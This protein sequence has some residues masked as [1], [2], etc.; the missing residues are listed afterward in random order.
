[1]TLLIAI[2][3]F[4]SSVFS[5]NQTRASS[6]GDDAAEAFVESLE[7]VYSELGYAANFNLQHRPTL[8]K[9]VIAAYP[10]AALDTQVY[11]TSGRV[12]WTQI[13]ANWNKM[14]TENKMT[15]GYIVLAVAHGEPAA[16]QALGGFV[17]GK[18]QSGGQ[19][20]KKIS[21]NYSSGG[22]GGYGSYASDGECSYISSGS[23]TMSTC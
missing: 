16:E 14:S 20:N 3:S 2:F 17:P 13:R 22:A 19:S 12:I 18:N 21:T 7:F 23:V 15:F 6:L 11:L 4:A 8:V 5:Q 1:M 9:S 10:N